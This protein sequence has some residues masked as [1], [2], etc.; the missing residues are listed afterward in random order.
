[1]IHISGHLLDQRHIELDEPVSMDVDNIEVHL[2]PL[3]G[4]RKK[5][6]EGETQ[7][8]IDR[9]HGCLKGENLLEDLLEERRRE[10]NW[11]QEHLWK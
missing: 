6:R 11:E 2:K 7:R 5:S 3:A 10:R 8:I 9:L 4:T 1:M